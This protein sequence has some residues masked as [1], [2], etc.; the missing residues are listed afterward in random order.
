MA[1]NFR[2]SNKGVRSSVASHSTRRLKRSQVNSRLR[3]SDGWSK[4]TA[5][6]AAFF[7]PGAALG[8]VV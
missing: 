7:S 6:G 1:K 8:G 3:Y 2:R 4:F 5:V